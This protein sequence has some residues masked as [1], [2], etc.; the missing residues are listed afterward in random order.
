[1]TKNVINYNDK[2]QVHGFQKWYMR[3]II[4]VMGNYKHNLEI[5]YNE[6]H[7]KKTTNFFIR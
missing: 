4:W 6:R 1:M 3:N 7:V 2:G 5:G